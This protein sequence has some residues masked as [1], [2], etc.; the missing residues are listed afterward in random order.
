V[1]SEGLRLRRSEM[2]QSTARTTKYH[3]QDTD[4]DCGEACAQIVIRSFEGGPL[5]EQE[6]LADALTLCPAPDESVDDGWGAN[7]HCLMLTLQDQRG[8]YNGTRAFKLLE[9]DS[10]EAISRWIVYSIF[11]SWDAPLGVA[12]S[13]VVWGNAHWVV[14]YACDVEGPNGQPV[15]PLDPGDQSYTIK[16]FYV[17][18]P[19]PGRQ[20]NEN[21]IPHTDNDQCGTGIAAPGQNWGL[22]SRRVRYNF[23]KKRWLTGI[24][25]DP[26]GEI[27]WAGKYVA[28]VDARAPFLA[29]TCPS[30]DQASPA[31]VAPPSASISSAIMRSDSAGNGIIG[32]GIIGE[33]IG[34]AEAGIAAPAELTKGSNGTPMAYEQPGEANKAATTGPTEGISLTRQLIGEEA[35][36][37]VAHEGLIADGLYGPDAPEPWGDVLRG[38]VPGRVHLIVPPSPSADDNSQLYYYL[39]QME[40]QDDSPDRGTVP[41]LV[42]V[43]A[44]EEELLEA[45]AVAQRGTNAIIFTAVDAITKLLTS[46]PLILDDSKRPVILEPGAIDPPRIIW[47]HAPGCLSPYAP[48]Y[49]FTIGGRHI[50]IRVDDRSIFRLFPP[51]GGQAVDLRR[52]TQLY[53]T[54]GSAVP[55]EKVSSPWSSNNT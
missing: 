34:V 11:S 44:F 8:S 30:W 23:W 48:F 39:V 19:A 6:D 41:V 15:N 16:A 42:M 46:A 45:A 37:R 31:P 3:R 47:Q 28:V 36:K 18:D 33:S 52:Y 29:T 24:P 9:C 1:S 53:L 25:A 50:Y 10:E 54:D 2:Y 22:A 20:W 38:A 14:V 12:P 40:I 35:A 4:K 27:Y 13:V 43:D 26:T 21:P 55:P 49:D 17:R 51:L 5:Y 32:N 7:P